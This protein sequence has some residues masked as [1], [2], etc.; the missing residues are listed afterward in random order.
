MSN[1]SKIVFSWSTV[2]DLCQ[3]R[4][5]ALEMLDR[6]FPED[7]GFHLLTLS[8]GPEFY[9]GEEDLRDGM[10][11]EA[12]AVLEKNH[13]HP[14]GIVERIEAE[15]NWEDFD[16]PLFMFK[17]E[18]NEHWTFVQTNPPCLKI[19]GTPTPT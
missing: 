18:E 7:Q 17:S 16:P 4:A 9:N 2:N 14:E 12:V 1:Y 6:I 13:I 8:G 5:E 15:D 19:N 3:S 11:C 10:A